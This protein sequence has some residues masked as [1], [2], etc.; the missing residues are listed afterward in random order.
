MI[1]FYDSGI[2]G[3][4]ILN[5]FKKLRPEI[6]TTYLADT[7]NMPLGQ[8]TPQEIELAVQEGIIE[9]FDKGGCSLVVLACNTATCIAIKGIQSYWLPNLNNSGRYEDKKQVLGIVR[10]VSEE[11]IS[12][13]YSK[14]DKIII[15]ATQATVNSGFYKQELASFGYD[16][17]EELSGQNLAF[18]IEESFK[19]S[20]NKESKELESGTSKEIE[21]TLEKIFDPKNPSNTRLKGAK[22]IVLACTHYPYIEQQ[23]KNAYMA[24]FMIEKTEEVEIISQSLLVAHKLSEY[25]D[26]HNIR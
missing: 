24:N 11:L 15:L 10:P 12:K 6:Q 17:I 25:I 21:T 14:Q 16:N 7:K 13:G 19:T 9:L 2:G 5:E 20:D 3:L 4:T 1:G 23:I 18:L 22:A 26:E 8:K